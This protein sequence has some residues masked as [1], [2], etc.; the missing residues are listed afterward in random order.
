MKKLFLLIIIIIIP[1]FVLSQKTLFDSLKVDSKTKII[2]R[3]PHYDKS[4]TYEKYNFIINDST[5]IVDFI[6]NI[7]LGEEV[8]NSLENPNFRLSVVKNN[9]EIGTWTVNPKQKSVMTHDGKTYKFDLNQISELNKDFPL[10]YNNEV[11]IFK[12]KSEYENYLIEQKKNSNFLFDYAPQFEYEGSFEIEFKKSNE[13]S[14]P[15]AI[16]DFVS[17][18]IEKIVAK[19]EYSLSYPLNDKNRSNFEQYTMVIQGSKK[20][21]K[22]LKLKKIKNENWKPTIEDGIFFY[23]K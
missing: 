5:K 20:I 17:P 15:K 6:K 11:V 8:P 2:G 7:K 23:S 22:E 18:L 4:K 19:G 16:S 12:S 14:S 1:N 3:N 10:S 9:K 13:F 21:F